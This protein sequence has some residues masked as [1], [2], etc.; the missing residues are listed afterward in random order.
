MATGIDLQRHYVFMYCSPSRSA[1]HTGRNPLHVNVGGALRW[2]F[3]RRKSPPPTSARPP[4]PISRAHP[5]Q[6]LNNW[7]DIHN[8]ADPIAGYQGVPLNMTF[9]PEKL[10]A[11]GYATHFVGKSHMGMATPAHIPTARG[12][13]T[14]LHYFTG[15]NDVRLPRAR[16][17]G[18]LPPRREQCSHPR[19]ASLAAAHTHALL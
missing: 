8:P 17:G 16:T 4:R 5:L 19:Y 18:L 10:K 6:V 7:L 14:S 2:P 3:S 12:Y 11:A 9:L 1:L 15:A 13:D